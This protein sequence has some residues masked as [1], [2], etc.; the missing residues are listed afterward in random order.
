MSSKVDVEVN[1]KLNFILPSSGAQSK[2]RCERYFLSP[3]EL[4]YREKRSRKPVCVSKLEQHTEK[5]PGVP[6]GGR[7]HFGL[8]L[9][10]I[11]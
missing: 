7:T 3:R 10:F 8:L 9:V 4:T 2:E 6:A 11:K 5:S 1:F